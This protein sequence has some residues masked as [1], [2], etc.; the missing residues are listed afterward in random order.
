MN[1][2]VALDFR[3]LSFVTL[4][5]SFIFG[6]GLAVFAAK[7][8]KFRS[9]ALVGSGFLIMGLGYVLLGMRHVLPHVVTIVIANS[10]IYLSLIMVYRGLFRFLSV[11]LSRESI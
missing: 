4:L 3:T 10:L 2:I 9:L 6:F 1:A 11:S 8:Y 5:F 7:H